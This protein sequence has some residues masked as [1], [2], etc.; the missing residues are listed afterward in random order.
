ME[1]NYYEECL[2]KIRH[3]IET[4]ELKEAEMLLH[5]ELSMPYIPAHVEN[6]LLELKREIKTRQTKESFTGILP[7]QIEEALLSADPVLQLRAVQ[8]LQDL[9]CR[10]YLDVIQSFFDAIPDIKTQALMI[11]ILIE[12]QISEE[13]EIVYEGMNLTFIPRYQERPHETDGYQC[14]VNYLNE[15][16][17][18]ENP[19]LLS[20]CH[21]MLIQECFLMLPMAYEQEEALSLAVSIAEQVSKSLDDGASFEKI[22][23][24][25]DKNV[26]RCVLKSCFV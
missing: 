13:F 12:Q 22:E 25:I 7:H 5:E 16:F 2:T 1:H 11:D 26:K 15:W 6:R 3:L 10:N 17:E 14:A 18:N 4:N 9:N 23:K 24:Q 20:M 19:A 8:T 21:Q